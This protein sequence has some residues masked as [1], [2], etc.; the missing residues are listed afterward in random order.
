MIISML[1]IFF[2][3]EKDGVFIGP[4]SFKNGAKKCLI[5]GFRS[6]GRTTAIIGRYHCLTPNTGW[7]QRLTKLGDRALA[8]PP[9]DRGSTTAGSNNCRRYHRPEILGGTAFQAVPPLARNSGAELG[10]QF[11]PI[12][13]Y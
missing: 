7:Y 4:N 12:Q 1:F 5:L 9:P 13:P 2:H 11:G 8:V 6:P 3:A 10:A